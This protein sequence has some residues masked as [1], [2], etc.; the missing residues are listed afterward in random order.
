[1]GGGL[2][3]S[4]A[5]LG[6]SLQSVKLP[7]GLQGFWFRFPAGTIIFLLVLFVA[8]RVGVAPVFLPMQAASP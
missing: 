1:M 3:P 7:T 4:S 6:T 8:L 2:Q 5:L